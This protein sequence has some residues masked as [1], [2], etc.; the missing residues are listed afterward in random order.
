MSVILI[1]DAGIEWPGTSRRLREAFGSPHSG[2]EFVDYAI[3]NLGFVGIDN[4]GASCQL[5]LRPSL[6]SEAC[7]RGVRKW[8]RRARLERVVVSSLETNWSYELVRSTDVAIRRVETLIAQAE[9]VRPDDFLSRRLGLGE[10]HSASPLGEIVRN[11]SN[12]SQPSGQH[13]LRELV[14]ATLGDRYVVVERNASNGQMIFREFGEGLFSRY[15]TWRTCAV[16]APME[17]QPDRVYGHWVASTYQDVCDV[18]E[19]SVASVDAIVRWPH[20]GRMRMR[21]QRIIIPL[22]STTDTPL[23]MGGSLI[24][25]GIDLRMRAV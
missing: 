17:E 19:P 15:E 5:R 14:Q 7:W 1:D 18:R 25:S 3:T 4:F 20:A 12:L 23:L 11:W 16:G 2:S 13:R 24:D 21:Y 6:I 22:N 8:L 10:L 9:N